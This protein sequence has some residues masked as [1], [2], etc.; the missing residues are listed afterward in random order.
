MHVHVHVSADH[1]SELNKYGY[2][3]VTTC[4]PVK[5]IQLQFSLL[6]NCQL[7]GDYLYVVQFIQKKR[8]R[9]VYSTI[10]YTGCTRIPLM[11]P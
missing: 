2:S 7:L 8:S 4:I 6:L 3:H 11:K 10:L 5:V 9:G 1:D